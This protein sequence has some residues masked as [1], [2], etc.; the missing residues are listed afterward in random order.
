MPTTNDICYY[1]ATTNLQGN[2]TLSLVGNPTVVPQ[3]PCISF[4]ANNCPGGQ[5][6]V[7]Q[8]IYE[9]IVDLP[10]AASDWKFSWSTCCRNAAITTLTG[11]GG[12][13]S[14][15]ACFGRATG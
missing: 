14:R 9:A 3:S 7:E 1:S 2:A 15:R 6:D 12:Q 13:G 5:G 8:Y 4:P 11:A 10:A